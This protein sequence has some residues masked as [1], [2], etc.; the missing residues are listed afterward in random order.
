[1]Q[2]AVNNAT[3]R[4]PAPVQGGASISDI[5]TTL[6]NLVV[7]VNNLTQTYLAVNG[8]LVVTGV[9]APSLCKTSAGRLASVS[10]T[11]AGSAVGHVYDTNQLGAS[12]RVLYVIPTVV[13]TYFVNLPT[14]F[15]ILAVPGTGQV[16]AV[17]WS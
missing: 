5:L 11:T 4:Q 9:A 3:G 16:I 10:V 2:P 13:G 6:K 17:S 12:A 15:G 7:A 8:Q 14:S 1:M